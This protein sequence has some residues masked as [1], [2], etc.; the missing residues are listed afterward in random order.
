MVFSHR[1]I[2]VMPWYPGILLWYD[3]FSHIRHTVLTPSSLR[4][5]CLT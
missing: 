3:S 5:H 1:F 2:S 4:A